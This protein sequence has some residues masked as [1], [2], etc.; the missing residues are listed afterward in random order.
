MKKIL[1]SLILL[2]VVLPY[3]LMAITVQGLTFAG[4]KI[5]GDATATPPVGLP[6]ILPLGD[7][8]TRGSNDNNPECCFGYRDHLQ[9]SLGVGVY[10]FV[11]NFSEPAISGTYDI[12]HEG[13]AGQT[14]AQIL[15]RLQAGLSTLMP[16]PNPS[17]S[18]VLIIAGTNDIRAS[19]SSS[20]VRAAAVAN[21]V[22]MV[23]TIHAYDAS[24]SI[25][26]ALIPP[27]NVAGIDT[28]FTNYNTDL[29]SAMVT[30]QGTIT[31]LHIVDMN[32]AIKNPANCTA[33]YIAACMSDGLHPDDSTP[34]RGY[35][36]LSNQWAS[37]ISNPS[38]TGCDGN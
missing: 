29:N 17:G 14:T 4:M 6:R 36:V 21:V 8:I 31:N 37:C 13:V 38:N 12:N 35:V 2:S 25:Y 32:G 30:L 1:C 27:N 33:S 7:S 20:T 23:N 18:K 9:D 22:T 24:I 5:R 3:P 10:D 26:V 34:Y 15:A 19:P 11:G 28:G 16:L